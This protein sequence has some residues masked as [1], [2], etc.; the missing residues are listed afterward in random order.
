[1]ILLFG[2]AYRYTTYDDNTFATS[3]SDGETNK[4]SVI[5]LP[6][7]FLQDEISLTNQHKY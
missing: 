6:G 1:M 2:I 7:V 5:H 4:P 3:E